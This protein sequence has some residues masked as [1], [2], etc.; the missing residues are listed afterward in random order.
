[1]NKGLK[2]SLALAAA[3]GVAATGKAVAD[4][5][6]PITSAF[7]PSDQIV[8]TRNSHQELGGSLSMLLAAEKVQ[9]ATCTASAATTCATTLPL[10]YVSTPICISIDATTAAV[11]RVNGS[12]GTGLVTVTAASSS[13][14]FNIACFA[15]PS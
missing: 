2:I 9:V 1:M 11:S 4:I 6:A 13:D 15:N 10:S 5:V 14:T 3:I 12:A 7:L 8:V